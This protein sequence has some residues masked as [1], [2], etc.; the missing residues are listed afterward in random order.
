MI[1]H[2][3][4]R[5]VC[6]A[7]AKINLGLLVTGKRG[8]GYHDI[9]TV[10]HRV[11]LA[12]RVTLESSEGITVRSSDPAAPAGAKNICHAAA[13]LVAAE[14]GTTRGVTV[15]LRKSIPVGAGLGGGSS[16]AAAVLLALP[17][18]WGA[19]LPPNLLGALALR[20]G[21]DVPY[22]LRRG[23]ALGTGRGENLEY[24]TLDIPFAILLCTPRVSVSSAWAYSRITP[25]MR[26]RTDLRA[27][28]EAGFRDPSLLAR[29]LVNDFEE[30]V[31]REYPLI[32]SIKETLVAAGALFASLSGSGS[33]VY[34]FFRSTAEAAAAQA[35]L[36]GTDCLTSV[37]PPHW[38][39]AG[40]GE[41][42]EP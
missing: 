8:D 36:P 2:S 29:E 7:H 14:L 17:R 42:E 5:T 3:P 23:S 32:G 31:F 1:A 22:F 40:A 27:I 11:A 34:A 26:P 21:S 12:D 15:D 20:L 6:R 30:P 24:F 13:R 10:F 37:T 33:S 25:R 38:N 39:D 41:E 19:E 28:L 4:H 16:D 9:V 35:A 18:F